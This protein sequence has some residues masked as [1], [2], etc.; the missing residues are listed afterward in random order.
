[1][2]ISL[3]KYEKFTTE[4]DEETTQMLNLASNTRFRDFTDL[5]LKQCYNGLNTAAKLQY[6]YNNMV[7]GQREVYEN[8]MPNV[9]RDW[10]LTGSPIATMREKVSISSAL[11]LTKDQE[12]EWLSKITKDM[13]DANSVTCMSLTIGRLD[14]EL[15][16]LASIGVINLEGEKTGGIELPVWVLDDTG[17]QKDVVVTGLAFGN[18]MSVQGLPEIYCD[19]KIQLTLRKVN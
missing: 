10:V 15:C 12:E 7:Y 8:V 18:P 9:M 13:Y 17:I 5:T 4:K 1:M 16:V 6:A 19:T 3:V 2:L 14:N 11:G